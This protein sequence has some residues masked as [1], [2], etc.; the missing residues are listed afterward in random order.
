MHS[1]VA[2]LAIIATAVVAKTIVID[3]GETGLVFNPDSTAADVGDVLEFHFYGPF[4]T[5]T[6]SD[7]NN[8]CQM[9]SSG[10]NSGPIRNQQ[11]GSVCPI[12]LI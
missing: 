6:Q 5:A 2:L 7:F 3:A 1:S 9:L 8:P 10:F 11:D 4:H 12:F